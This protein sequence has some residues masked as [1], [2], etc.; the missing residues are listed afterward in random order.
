MDMKKTSIMAT[1]AA[2]SAAFAAHAQYLE[3][4]ISADS[5]Q[6]LQTFADGH[7]Y[8]LGGTA[9][10]DPA[11]GVNI[12]DNENGLFVNSLSGCNVTSVNF[13][14]HSPSP[15]GSVRLGSQELT[16]TEVPE[17]ST[18]LLIGLGAMLLGARLTRQHDTWD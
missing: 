18:F 13:V 4:N 2:A 12:R 9:T 15:G 11:E 3:F 8:P 16:L 14:N 17:P 10:L 1:L 5:N 7:N 6:N